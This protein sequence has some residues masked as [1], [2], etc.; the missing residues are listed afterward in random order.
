MGGTDPVLN[1]KDLEDNN[2]IPIQELPD[3]GSISEHREGDSVEN[4]NDAE[5]DED[6]ALSDNEKEVP[7][8]EVW[9]VSPLSGI[10]IKDTEVQ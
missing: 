4:G 7:S 1:Q 2:L 8:K 5:Y 9:I 10:E 3:E 6:V